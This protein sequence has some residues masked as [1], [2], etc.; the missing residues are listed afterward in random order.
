MIKNGVEYSTLKVKN[1]IN[2]CNHLLSWK[3][4]ISGTK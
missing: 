3:E 1:N 2:A 4:K